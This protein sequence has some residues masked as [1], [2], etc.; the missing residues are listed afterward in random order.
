MFIDVNIN[1]LIL[2]QLPTGEFNG[3]LEDF[4]KFF[5]AE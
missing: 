4:L 2:K 1:K 5:K 3:F